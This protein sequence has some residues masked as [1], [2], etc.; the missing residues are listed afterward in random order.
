MQIKI[1]T[2]GELKYHNNGIV[3]EFN[4]VEHGVLDRPLVVIYLCNGKV[5]RAIVPIG[6]ETDFGT[7]PKMFGWL[8]N[9][10]GKGAAAY[11]LHDWLCF[12]VMTD[13]RKKVDKI[14]Q[15]ALINLGVAH[16]EAWIAY[17]AVRIFN[18]LYEKY[19]RDTEREKVMF[20]MNEHLIKTC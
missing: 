4:G 9:P 1:L 12:A 10:K 7:V 5:E 6:F 8:V 13:N 11:V 19:F 15:E 18:P 20:S 2:I 14:M 3:S 16:W 17:S